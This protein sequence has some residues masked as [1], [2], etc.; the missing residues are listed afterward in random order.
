MGIED[1]ELRQDRL[2]S[3]SGQFRTEGTHHGASKRRHGAPEEAGSLSDKN[4]K[5][6]DH[7]GKVTSHCLV[8]RQMKALVEMSLEEQGIEANRDVGIRCG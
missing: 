6:R 2:F 4:G 1:K 7:N 5:S 8:D 3:N